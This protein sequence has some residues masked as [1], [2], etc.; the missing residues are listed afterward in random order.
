M[1]QNEK[2]TDITDEKL[3]DVKNHLHL[4]REFLT[5]QDIKVIFELIRKEKARNK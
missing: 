3:D 1:M 2:I 4:G 5:Y